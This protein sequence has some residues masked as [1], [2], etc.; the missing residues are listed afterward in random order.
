MSKG[1]G[2]KQTIL[3]LGKGPNQILA[4]FLAS[5][6]ALMAMKQIIVVSKHSVRRALESAN[7]KADFTKATVVALPT[8][9]NRAIPV[10]VR[11]REGNQDKGIGVIAEN[12]ENRTF[13]LGEVIR[14]EGGND[15]VFPQ[16]KARTKQPNAEKELRLEVAKSIESAIRENQS[17][18]LM[19]PWFQR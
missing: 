4:P 18:C 11:I 15:F 6:N 14:Y 9:T 1:V 16:F 17:H 12:P 3:S 7:K 19:R 2:N 10:W 5:I 13:H 8:E